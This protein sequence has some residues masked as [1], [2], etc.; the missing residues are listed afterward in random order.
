MCGIFG[1]VGE[2]DPR[3]VGAALALADQGLFHRGPDFGSSV[4]VGP[5][6][7]VSRRLAIIDRSVQ[8][9]QP[10]STSDRRHWLVYNGM[11]YNYRELR[12]ELKPHYAFRG[13]SDTE[14]VLAALSHWGI[15]ALRRFE[16]MFAFL[17]WDSLESALVGAVDQLGIKPLLYRR[18]RS[19]VLACSS[20]QGPLIDIFP[21]SSVDMDALGAYLSDGRIDH[22]SHTL[23]KDVRQLRRGE[24]LRWTTTS[25][26][27]RRYSELI[28]DDASQ[29][30]K[31]SDEAAQLAVRAALE[32]SLARHVMSEVPVGLGL[33][34]GLDSNLLRMVLEQSLPD[35]A[36]QPFTYTFPGSFYDESQR[37]AE[38]DT[39]AAFNAVKVPL[40]PQMV[41]DHLPEIINRTLEPLGGLGTFGLAM[42]YR[43]AAERGYRVMLSGEGADDLFGGYTY[44]RREARFAVGSLAETGSRQLVRASDGSFLNGPALRHDFTF[45]APEPDLGT[46]AEIAS[47]RSV[48]RRG[49]WVDM[50]AHRLPKLLRFRDRVSM[51]HS[52]EAR[53]P[54]LDAGMLRL[55]LGLPDSS[56][57]RGQSTKAVLRDVAA[58]GGYRRF[59]VEK[60]G[61][62]APQ[63]EWI[64]GSL[65]D[66][67]EGLLADSALVKAGIVDG[68]RFGQQL[69]EYRN[70][71]ELGNS[72]FAWQFAN[73]EL[74]MRAFES[75]RQNGLLAETRRRVD[76]SRLA[77]TAG[78][79]AAR[80]NQPAK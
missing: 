1:L 33:S 79:S 16:G 24:Y 54:F 36:I 63:R 35:V 76:A 52:I 20:E 46:A 75:R 28:V 71:A 15:A 14:V 19:G 44:L 38:I 2:T 67:I 65:G 58:A 25:F 50:S 12:E 68:P 77:T 21:N 78:E 4:V 60:F 45:S 64:K 6:A 8:G 41:V 37:L 3:F 10:M 80:A 47:Q 7:L 53:V 29:E 57:V 69:A 13:S 9:A 70:S 26:Q 48:L 73:L 56:L 62:P 59:S 11:L 22:S 23:V 5:A 74:W 39:P 18:D 40:R 43:A 17:W 34:S 66:W 55:S 51:I 27:V 72:F 42:K 61:N 32:K 31:F 30:E 49:M